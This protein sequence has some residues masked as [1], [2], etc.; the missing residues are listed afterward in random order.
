MPSPNDE[1]LRPDTKPSVNVS[2]GCVAPA[3]LKIVFSNH[4]ADAFRR[5]GARTGAH[6]FFDKAFEFGR[7]RT[8]L[9]RLAA[10]NR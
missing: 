6:Y 7:L 3:M 9:T 5:A 2:V 4:V 10:E 8:L 1:M